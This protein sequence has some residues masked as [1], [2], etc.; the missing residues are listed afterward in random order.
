MNNN[1]HMLQLLLLQS[2]DLPHPPTN[3]FANVSMEGL[4]H[5]LAMVACALL[6]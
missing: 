3:E 4:Q 2:A 6:K 5:K 1:K